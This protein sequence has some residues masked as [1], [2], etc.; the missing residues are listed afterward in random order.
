ML[1]NISIKIAIVVFAT[2][3]LKPSE[4]ADNQS[5]ATVPTAKTL[6]IKDDGKKNK[7]L[8]MR[9]FGL[10]PPPPDPI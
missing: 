4:A 6:T 10:C 2:L 3:L 7:P 1:K 5:K 9:I 8:C